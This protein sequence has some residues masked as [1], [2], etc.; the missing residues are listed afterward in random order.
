MT[1][2]LA[3][4]VDVNIMTIRIVARDDAGN[5]AETVLPVDVV[6]PLQFAYDGNRELAEYYEPVIVNGPI[7]GGIGTV[8]TY[9]ES[10][11]ES[12]QRAVSMS[13]TRTAATSRGAA[14]TD[15]WNDSYGVTETVSTANQ[16]SA[17]TS[18]TTTANETYGDTW[19][20]SD[21]TQVGTSST[22]GTTWGWNLVEGIEQEQYQERLD[23]LSRGASTS[24]NAEV[25][26]SGSIPGFASVSGKVGTEVGVDVKVGAEIL[27]GERVGSSTDRGTSAGGSLSDTQTFGSTTT[28]ARSQSAGGSWGLARQDAIT[29]TTTESSATADSTVFQLGGSE[30]VT[31]GYTE[32]VAEA[33][34][35]TWQSTST[36]TTL[37][38]FSGKIPNGRCA[39]VYRQTVRHVRT[40]Y[41]YQY[42]R[43][44]VRDVVGEFFFN[45]WSW[46]PNIAIG[47]D[48][49][50]SVPASTQPAAA[51]F[52]A[53]R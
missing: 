47:D 17:S 9:A 12:R 23:S 15:T 34:S 28:D 39:V 7:V 52:Y 38:S 45:E 3:D 24:V 8:V 30:T 6:R 49:A 27:D 46:S 35:E 44:G 19:T 26:A 22:D 42:D 33:W 32:G 40:A 29:T 36:D 25:G 2:P 18:E 51:C 16:T 10:Q 1:N 20:Q 14:S 50:T 21:A 4:D 48:C 31:E 13:V 41:L 11:T 37:L 43:C 53:C 5:S